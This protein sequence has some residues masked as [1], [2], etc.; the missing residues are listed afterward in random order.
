[1]ILNIGGVF[2][3]LVYLLIYIFYYLYIIVGD[4]N[5]KQRFNL[6]FIPWWLVYEEVYEKG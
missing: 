5:V 3:D 1:M 4:R 6:L 2:S